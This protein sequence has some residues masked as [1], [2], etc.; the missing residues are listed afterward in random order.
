VR[1][2]IALQLDL[3]DGAYPGEEESEVGFSDTGRKVA[4]V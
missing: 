3:G 2:R 1:G 4:D